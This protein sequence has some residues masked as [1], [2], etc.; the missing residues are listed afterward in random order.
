M[1]LPAFCTPRTIAVLLAWTGLSFGGGYLLKQ[2]L[3]PSAT[4]L[5]GSSFRI[6]ND[7]YPLIDPLLGCNAGSS[8]PTPSLDDLQE[9]LQTLVDDATDD[10]R[11]QQASI[12]LRDMIPGTWTGINADDAYTPASL[13]KVPILITYLKQAE[14][15]PDLLSYTVTIT[16]D[17][18]AGSVQDIAPEVSVQVGETYSIEELL[19][20]MI[21]DS[22]NRA[23]NVL[24]NYIDVNVLQQ[25]FSDLGVTFPEDTSSYAISPRTYS[26]FF[27]I[28]YN[29]T[30]LSPESSQKAL[31]ILSRATFNEGIR[32][33]VPENITVAH[34][35]GE[36]SAVLASGEQGHEL[37]DCGMVYTENPYALCVMTMGENVDDL[38]AFLEDVSSVVYRDLTSQHEDR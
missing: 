5:L 27:R 4:D 25:A 34:K 24:M 12:Y 3:T 14:Y 22:D 18:A 32:A 30:Y 15:N 19:S 37:H 9:D 20:F 23:L 31:L 16:E 35:F 29:A 7:P 2:A 8:V 11:I 10:G 36:A 17:P 1:R 28:L 6:N 13:F 21:V 38:S 33:G 26:R